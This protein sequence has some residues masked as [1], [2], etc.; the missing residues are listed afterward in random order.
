MFLVALPAQRTLAK[1]S[2][3][4]F[5][6]ERE[7]RPANPGSNFCITVGRILPTNKALWLYSPHVY[8]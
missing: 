6:P 2:A 4:S 5:G 3:Y 8:N 1:R 7:T